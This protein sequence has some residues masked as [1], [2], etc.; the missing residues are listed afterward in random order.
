MLLLPRRQMRLHAWFRRFTVKETISAAD[1][2]STTRREPPSVE[3]TANNN[4]NDAKNVPRDGRFAFVSA[5]GI[6]PQNLRELH[7]YSSKGKLEEFPQ[8]VGELLRRLYMNGSAVGEGIM[9][10]INRGRLLNEGEA[11]YVAVERDEKT[12]RNRTV[13]FLD[14]H[15]AC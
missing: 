15:R 11:I 8:K 13:A 4:S 1:T 7:V 3:Q 10:I 6:K 12:N 14:R 9:A 5:F 2:E